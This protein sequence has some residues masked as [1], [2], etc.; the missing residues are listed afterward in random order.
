MELGTSY[1]PHKNKMA[2][3]DT[4]TDVKHQPNMGAGAGQGDGP[5]T[6]HQ[7]TTTSEFTKT[8]SKTFWHYISNNPDRRGAHLY[9]NNN[10]DSSLN[11]DFGAQYIP[12]D[13]CRTTMRPQDWLEAWRNASAFRITKHSVTIA[14][15]Q[16][17]QESISGT[18]TS[19]QSQFI[20]NPSTWIYTDPQRLFGLR[21]IRPTAVNESLYDVNDN[22]QIQTP[23]SQ[24]QGMLK[25][26]QIDLGVEF[27]NSMGENFNVH[28]D[29]LVTDVN[30]MLEIHKIKPGQSYYHETVYD[31][32]LSRWYPIGQFNTTEIKDV[33][34]ANRFRVKTCPENTGYIEANYA[35][36]VNKNFLDETKP[37]MLK[38]EDYHSEQGAITIIAKIKVTYVTEIQFKTRYD[39]G[40]NALQLD[41]Q[42]TQLN[43]HSSPWETTAIPKQYFNFNR[44]RLLTMYGVGL[45]YNHDEDAVT[46][47]APHQ[48]ETGM[49]PPRDSKAKSVMHDL[50]SNLLSSFAIDNK[51]GPGNTP[52]HINTSTTP[53]ATSTP[54]KTPIKV[55]RK[56]QIAVPKPSKQK[57]LRIENKILK[58]SAGV[59]I[60]PQYYRVDDKGR[61]APD[62]DLDADTND[63]QV[64]NRQ[65]NAQDQL[66]QNDPTKD[67]AFVWTE[68]ETDT[69]DK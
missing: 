47:S 7:Q 69:D 37:I 53:F 48:P 14:D 5:E 61:I 21:S 17:I 28:P 6:I 39:C 1:A 36:L 31:S 44:P 54:T 43:N 51:P 40:F 55:K 23:T 2:E 63:I 11:I 57:K 38:I 26:C 16:P 10:G 66:R 49:Q 33:A 62:T 42:S 13:N 52:T 65:D 35:T 12:Y 64:I 30:G 24:H 60:F 8:Y 67:P 4:T 68:G 15:I 29:Q 41:G 20:N 19:I 46:A 58:D 45:A 25:R 34:F 50:S 18:S 9:V 59:P 56:S 27:T 32:A 22:M 3:M